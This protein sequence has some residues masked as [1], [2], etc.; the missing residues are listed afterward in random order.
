MYC[1]L[2]AVFYESVFTLLNY[3]RIEFD[4][5][6]GYHHSLILMEFKDVLIYNDEREDLQESKW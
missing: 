1:L 2:Q 3:N 6:Q 4:I 5:Y